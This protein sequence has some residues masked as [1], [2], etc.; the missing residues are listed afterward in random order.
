MLFVTAQ[1]LLLALFATAHWG[2]CGAQSTDDIYDMDA[3]NNDHKGRTGGKITNPY[4]SGCLHQ[5]MPG[6]TKKRVCAAGTV[7]DDNPDLCRP[8]PFDEYLEIRIGAGN[9][10]SATALGWLMQI[11]LSEIV[12]VPTS[13]ES[14]AAGS[15]RNFYDPAGRVDYDRGVSSTA[16]MTTVK[17]LAGG[18]CRKVVKSEETYTPCK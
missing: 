14:G 10:D 2:W 6:W 13:F 9:W 11:I 18:D 17:E 3:S 1:W 8:P 12:G 16:A 15:S 4:Y 5:R 7:D